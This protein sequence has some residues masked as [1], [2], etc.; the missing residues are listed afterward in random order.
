MTTTQALCR[1]ACRMVQGASA[2]VHGCCM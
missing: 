2:G 1:F